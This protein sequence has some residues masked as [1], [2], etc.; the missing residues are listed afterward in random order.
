MS[1]IYNTTYSTA[2]IMLE[3]FELR[4]CAQALIIIKMKIV[5]SLITQLGYFFLWK[6][7]RKKRRDSLH[8]HFV[9]HLCP[10]QQ[11]DQ[12]TQYLSSDDKTSLNYLVFKM[13]SILINLHAHRSI[14]IY[15]IRDHFFVTKPE[16]VYTELTFLW[17]LKW[18]FEKSTCLW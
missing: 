18:P 2:T 11:G 15:I 10:I 3:L 16:I 5:T 13:S 4:I 7:H 1:T 9:C 8:Q 12:H 6:H 17:I 14:F